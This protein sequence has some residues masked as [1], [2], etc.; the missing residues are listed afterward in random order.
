MIKTV[1][2]REE[3]NHYPSANTTNAKNIKTIQKLQEQNGKRTLT[4][5]AERPVE[6]CK[7][8]RGLAVVLQCEV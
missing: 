7:D 4:L 2:K 1:Q 5:A 3:S 8:C 6:C